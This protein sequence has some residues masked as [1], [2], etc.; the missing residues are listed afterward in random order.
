MQGFRLAGLGG[1]AACTAVYPDGQGNWA[2]L[3]LRRIDDSSSLT[4]RGPIRF[5]H[6]D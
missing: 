4:P 6:P 3:R 2:Q 5:L 1:P